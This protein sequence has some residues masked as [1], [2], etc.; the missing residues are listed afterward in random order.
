MLNQ[1]RLEP[2]VLL[3]NCVLSDMRQAKDRETGREDTES[4]ADEK[5]VLALFSPI[6]A[7][8][9]DDEREYIIADESSDLAKGCS[10]SVI[11]TANGGGGGL[12]CD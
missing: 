11:L 12:R 9:S 8:C 2:Q 1:V 3:L 6:V 7:C 4:T 10:D 5:R